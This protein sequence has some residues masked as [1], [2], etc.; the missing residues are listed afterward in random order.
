[1]IV[2]FVQ[3]IFL[4][5]INPFIFFRYPLNINKYNESII[6][7]MDIIATHVGYEYNRPI[8]Q[9]TPLLTYNMTTIKI[10]IYPM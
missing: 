6:T 1:M 8:I 3:N 7:Y 2:H 4:L 5:A 10:C 9:F